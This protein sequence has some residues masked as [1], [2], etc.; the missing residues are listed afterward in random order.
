MSIGYENVQSLINMLSLYQVDYFGEKGYP[1]AEQRRALLH[2]RY[3]SFSNRLCDFLFTVGDYK[4]VESLATKAMGVDPYEEKNYF[5]L[6]KS[7]QAQNSEVKVNQTYQNYC[8]IMAKELGVRPHS[9]S[10]IL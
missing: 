4:S 3:L 8:A 9:L 5:S 7:Y 1:W 2:N 10:E 6:I